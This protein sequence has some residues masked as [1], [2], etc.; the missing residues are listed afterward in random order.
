MSLVNKSDIAKVVQLDKIGLSG[1]AK[2]IMDILRISDI[3][4][5]YSKFE[6][7][8][9]VEFIDAILKEFKVTF[10]YYEEELRRIPKEGPFI[11]ISNHPLGG[12]DGIIL[13]KLISQV[14]P[15]YKV[16]ANFLLQKVEP[17]KEFIMPVNPFDNKDI[18]SSFTG[19]KDSMEHVKAGHPLGIFPAGE[20]S[21]YKFEE[22][23]IS[24]KPW[25][26]SAIKMIRKM[27][28]PV[29]P[30]YFKA[31]NSAFF[32]LLSALHPNL[33]TAKLPS[34][35]LHQKNKSIRIRIGRA[36]PVKEQ[37]GY[38]TPEHYGAFLRQR[39]YLLR[40]AL[41]PEKKLFSLKRPDEPK[42]IIAP[43]ATEILE[44]ELEALRST[45]AFLFEQKNY[46]LFIAPS[47]RISNLLTE[48]G[49]LRELTFRAIG[50]GTN[51]PLDLDTYDYHYEHLI[52]WDKE[53][54]KLAGSYRLGI[55][56]DIYTRYGVKGFYVTTLFRVDDYMHDVFAKSLEMGR[57]FITREQ[58]LKPLPLFLLWR[59]I[60]LVLKR[61]PELEFITGCASISNKFSRF[62]KSLM[63]EYLTTHHG[64]PEMAEH[65]RPRKPFKPKLKDEHK[66]VVFESSDDDLNKFDRLIE[67]LEPGDMRFP[68]LIKKY[69]KQ[70][71]RIVCF[72]VDPLFNDSLDGFMYIR[73]SDL[74]E[75]TLSPSK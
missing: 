17:L 39:T 48:I 57:A 18:R 12:I 74:P 35:L 37:N 10:D 42:D 40:Q 36:I 44:A 31:R 23:K 56:S 34:E 15:D 26:E 33:R 32:Y 75:E 61:H 71:A 60:I 21:T 73:I 72:N 68:V 30:V 25:E 64:D 41:S 69:I 20:V 49:R 5:V 70:N 2:P 8:H 11:T 38:K 65:I 52:L 24:D 1:L 9:G 53:S 47:R 46:E 7:L 67:D 19:I 13:I 16:M 22:G 62:S 27:E 63:V 55:G 59:G 3:N 43:V 54:R 66:D 58:Q 50:E 28:V 4:E 6:E 29:I 51:L 14:R 45:N